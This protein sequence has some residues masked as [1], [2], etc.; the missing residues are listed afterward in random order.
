LTRRLDQ[1]VTDR[2]DAVRRQ[3]T[4]EASVRS[5]RRPEPIRIR[6]SSTGRPV[7]ASLPDVLT[8]GVVPGRPVRLRH[9]VHHVVAA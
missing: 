6:W 3:W 4:R 9:D 8:E 7:A 2:A 5:L 1:A